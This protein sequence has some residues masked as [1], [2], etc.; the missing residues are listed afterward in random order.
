MVEVPGGTFTLGDD[1]LATAATPAQPAITVGP[2]VLDA[3]EVTV[4][5]FRRFWEAGHPAPAG[6]IAYPGGASIPWT[7]E[8]RDPTLHGEGPWGT[9]PIDGPSP[10]PFHAMAAADWWTAQAFCVWDGGRL[11]TEAEWEFVAKAM[12]DGRPV[13]RVYPWGD[14]P[15]QGAV[16]TPC[17]LASWNECHPAMDRFQLG[18]GP[19]G[20]FAP[21]G[22]FYDL[23]GNVEE[24][25]ADGWALYTNASC[26]GGVPRA[27]PLCVSSP[28][29]GDERVTR[30]GHAISASTA[31]L[32]AAARGVNVS[33][34]GLSW[35][36]FRCAATQ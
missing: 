10:H 33:S 34:Q 23:A 6:A 32:R 4:A 28:D 8:V 13:P 19:V 5:R 7:G 31:A 3:Y 21:T 35:T 29:G 36:G 9:R 12:S 1:P 15:P 2:F 14:E 17:D 18:G 20:T 30:G 16:D 27:D 24:W 25:V 26:W 11:P 22:G